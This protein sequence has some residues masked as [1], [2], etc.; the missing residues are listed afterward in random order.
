MV[1]SLDPG[2]DCDAEFFAGPPPLAVRNVFLQECEEGVHRCVV[3]GR[4][5]F[6]H[7]PDEVVA[8]QGVHEASRSELESSVRVHD[9]PSSIETARYRVVQGVHRETGLHPAADRVA[10]DPPEELVFDRAQ[11]ELALVGPVLGDV[12]QP[13][14]VD[15]TCGEVPLDE[16]VVHARAWAF[17]VLTA[18]LPEHGPPL[19]ISADPPRGFLAHHFA[20]GAG[21]PSPTRNLDPNS[22][23][24]RWASNRA[25]AR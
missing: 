8:V 1:R 19:V 4:T 5:N 15:V 24:S 20:R 17:P 7:P 12:G 18:L 14:L 9:A 23:S 2:A 13:E 16:I 25:F 22:G 6:A 3:A 10:H 11:V 21:L